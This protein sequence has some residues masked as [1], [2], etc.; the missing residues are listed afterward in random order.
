MAVVFFPL[1]LLEAEAK[2][3]YLQNII[4]QHGQMGPNPGIV[5]HPGSNEQILRT[6]RDVHP[7]GFE[8]PGCQPATIS[9]PGGRFRDEDASTRCGQL[10][11]LLTPSTTK[12]R[13]NKPLI[14]K[15]SDTEKDAPSMFGR[16]LQP[17][18]ADGFFRGIWRNTFTWRF[19]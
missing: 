15:T 13:K 3:Y 5:L 10:S 16:A 12:A 1:I 18:S 9:I 7:P 14:K 8:A 19:R 11:C 4:Q 6:L 17:I 2:V